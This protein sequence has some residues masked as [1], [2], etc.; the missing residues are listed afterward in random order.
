MAVLAA[1]ALAIVWAMQALSRATVTAP[2]PARAP[3]GPPPGLEPDS[4]GARLAGQA[5][6]LLARVPAV[7]TDVRSPRRLTVAWSSGWLTAVPASGPAR[8]ADRSGRAYVRSGSCFAP[9]GKAARASAAG[10]VL[11]LSQPGVRFARP[12]QD[13]DVTV[14]RFD[15]RRLG[16]W[17]KGA[18]QVSFKAGAPVAFSYRPYGA[19]RAALLA[20][21]TYPPGPLPAPRLCR[22]RGRRAR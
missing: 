16:S 9:A 20:D 2:P 8:A 12:E 14:V 6:S 19:P 10:A 22:G 15:A 11:P 13:G 17:G 5:R 4:A 3:S 1:G 21:V 18:G 7:R